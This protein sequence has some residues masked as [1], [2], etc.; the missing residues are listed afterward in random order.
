MTL[1]RKKP[2]TVEAV[3]WDGT[4]IAEIWSV[5]GTEDIYGSTEL[6][7]E[8]LIYTLEGEM[9]ASPGDWI[10]R[11]VEGELYPCKPNIFKITYEKVV[12]LPTDGGWRPLP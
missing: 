11:G 9:H 2:V 1:F 4:N 12:E 5:F 8:L 6:D 3:Q 10:I 7:P